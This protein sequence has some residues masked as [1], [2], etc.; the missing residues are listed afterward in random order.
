MGMIDYSLL[1]AIEN[2][3]LGS[4]TEINTS[5]ISDDSEGEAVEYEPD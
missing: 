3:N 4:E 1:L 2:K 5:E